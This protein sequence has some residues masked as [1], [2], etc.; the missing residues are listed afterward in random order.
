GRGPGPRSRRPSLRGRARRPGPGAG[1]RA[2]SAGTGTISR[3]TLVVL[4]GARAPGPDGRRHMSPTPANTPTNPTSAQDEPTGATRDIASD[5]VARVL[6]RAGTA[7]AEGGTVHAEHDG[8]QL[9]LAERSALRRVAG[10][11]TEL[12]DVTEVEYRQLRL[13]KV[14]L[15]GIW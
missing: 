7:R 3:A 12:E 4:E 10:L 15:V 5:V 2:L 9:D 11:S 8:E 14:V 1:P 6:A 13:E